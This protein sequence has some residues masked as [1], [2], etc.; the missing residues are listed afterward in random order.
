MQL[1]VRTDI[2]TG[3]VPHPVSW[4]KVECV[5]GGVE[6]VKVAPSQAPP[7]PLVTMSLSF[8]LSLNPKTH[9]NEVM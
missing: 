1:L 5:V 7:P 2:S 4:C 8:T 3:G 9:T 6:S